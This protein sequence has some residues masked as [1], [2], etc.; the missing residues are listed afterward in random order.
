MTTIS[1]TLLFQVRGERITVLGNLWKR[2]LVDS[3]YLYKYICFRGIHVVLEH[4]R[5]F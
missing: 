4:T 3:F 1:T 5:T 2:N